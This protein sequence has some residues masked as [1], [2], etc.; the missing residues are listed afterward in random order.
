MLGRIF[1]SWVFAGAVSSTPAFGQV[2]SNSQVKKLEA[3]ALKPVRDQVEEIQK[4]VP[5]EILKSTRPRSTQ[6]FNFL[7]LSQ[8]TV[9]DI[10]DLEGLYGKAPCPI[11]G[12]SVIYVAEDAPPS[13][14]LHEYAHY[15]QLTNEKRWCE[16]E[17]S[18][19]TTEEKR[20]RAIM[21]HRFEFE[22]LKVLWTMRE[23]IPWLTFEDR[24]ILI[25]G[26]NRE[27]KILKQNKFEGLDE[28]TSVAL[29]GQVDA[30]RAQIELISWVRKKPQDGAA[31]IQKMEV[32]SLKACAEQT[33]GG[34]YLDRLNLCLKKRCQLG[35]FSC[36]PISQSDR[37]LYDDDL[38]LTVYAWVKPFKDQENCSIQKLKDEL[39]ERPEESTKC[40]KTWVASRSKNRQL[41]MV[42]KLDP[43]VVAKKY[44]APK[45]KIDKSISFFEANRPD[46]FL[47]QFYCFF[48]YQKSVS[49]EK[50]PPTQFGHAVQGASFTGETLL[51]Y[52]HWLTQNPSGQFCSKLVKSMTGQSP[53]MLKVSPK[54]MV[55]VLNPLALLTSGLSK[56]EEAARKAINHERLHHVYAQSEK[57]RNRVK[58]LW[59]SLKDDEREKFKSEHASYDFSSELILL[60]EYFSYHFQSEPEAYEAWL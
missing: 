5:I 19:L 22:V 24:L 41:G 3:L 58:T 53:Q 48:I 51:A 16:L 45:L 39:G 55:I 44:F 35:G 32:I 26:L 43:Q 29:Q 57:V 56:Y 47:N 15:L 36:Q 6:H 30:I 11:E 46:L 59:Q 27:D 23:T 40:W 4:D 8:K 25:E 42:K 14:L 54:A 21:Y 10:T 17:K 49:Y 20:E 38:G 2:L 9:A 28:A 7:P 34:S 12:K 50:L 60:R 31:V 37:K 33:L 52:Q 13:T 18:G 1:L